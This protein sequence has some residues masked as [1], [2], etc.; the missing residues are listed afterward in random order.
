MSLWP[1]LPLDKGNKDSGNKIAGPACSV[2]ERGAK[3]GGN[4]RVK[5]ARS[6]RRA[7]DERW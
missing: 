1:V 4:P 3:F 2:G 6:L 5:G 7:G